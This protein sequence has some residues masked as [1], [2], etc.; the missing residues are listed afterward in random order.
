MT[1]PR[2]HYFIPIDSSTNGKSMGTLGVPKPSG[3]QPGTPV[4]ASFFSKKRSR[5]LRNDGRYLMNNRSRYNGRGHKSVAT[6]VSNSSPIS[7]SASMTG[8]TLFLMYRA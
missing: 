3:N 7:R 2:A 6:R 5:V 4:K 1:T 8:I